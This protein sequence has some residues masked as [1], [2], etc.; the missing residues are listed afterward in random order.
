MKLFPSGI[1]L[2]IRFHVVS[3]I[4]RRSHDSAKQISG[5]NSPAAG[6]TELFKLSKDAGSLA[7][8]IKN[9]GKFGFE[10]FV[11]DVKTG[12]GLDTFGPRHR[13]EGPSPK[14][15]CFCFFLNK[16]RYVNDMHCF[17]DARCFLNL[18]G[19]NIFSIW[20]VATYA[21]CKL[22]LKCKRM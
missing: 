10:F 2:S 22:S 7:V 15:H 21:I 12:V 9:V 19:T 14:R 6:S 4:A 13:A 18:F 1:L 8:S 17:Y 11:S 5:H 20:C 16:T 3:F